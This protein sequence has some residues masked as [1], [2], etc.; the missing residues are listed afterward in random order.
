MKVVVLGGTGNFGARICRALAANPD[1]D[2]VVA[3]RGMDRAQAFASEQRAGAA[4]LDTAAPGFADRL[5]ILRP[6][7]VIHAAGPFQGQDHGV[8]LAVAA[9]GSHYIDLADGRRFVC[10]F[11]QAVNA[12]FRAAGRTAITGASTVPALSSAVVDAHLP[13]FWRLD[14]IDCCIA[15]A[16]RAPRGPATVAGV[17]SCCGGPVQVWKNGRWQEQSGWADPQSVKFARLKT[18]L[19]ALCDIPDLELFPKRYPGVTEVMFRAALEVAPAQYAFA[20]LAA[21]RRR[22]YLVRTPRLATVLHHAGKVF[23]PFGTSRGGMVVRMR[24]LSVAGAPAQLAWNIFAPHHHGPEIPCMAAILLARRLARGE[25][26]PP[27][28]MTCMGLLG[29][30]EFLPEFQRWGMKIDLVTEAVDGP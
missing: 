1:I 20:A 7:L 22:G 29:L 16:Q 2:L 26:L 25:A 30:Q 3:A 27:G 24:G 28:A 21:L 8:A 19:G 6:Q 17:L 18:R 5:A 11:A 23:D 14:A 12:P 10:D 9:A 15:P 4:A 13:R